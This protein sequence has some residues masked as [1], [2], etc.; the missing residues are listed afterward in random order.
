MSTDKLNDI[1]YNY[2]KT[3]LR[4]TYNFESKRRTPNKYDYGKNREKI[5]WR[6]S[7]TKK[8]G[9]LVVHNFGKAELRQY[10][11]KQDINASK[12]GR[13]SG[14]EPWK[15]AK[16]EQNSSFSFRTR[17]V[18]GRTKASS[19]WVASA[20]RLM[21]PSWRKKVA[22]SD[23]PAS[24][25][26]SGSDTADIDTAQGQKRMEEKGIRKVIDRTTSATPAPH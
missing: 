17:W 16:A 24:P 5:L 18:S 13:A 11:V 7:N 21:M 3:E 15:R 22:A 10:T 25:V 2:W 9:R 19:W 26:A 1:G 14:N 20:W 23:A 6:R 12:D 8:S 4:Q